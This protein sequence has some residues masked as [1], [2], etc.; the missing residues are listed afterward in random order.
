MTMTTIDCPRYFLICLMFFFV[1]ALFLCDK[2]TVGVGEAAVRNRLATE[3]RLPPGSSALT[4]LVSL[5]NATTRYGGDWRRAY[6][7]QRH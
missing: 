3:L 1:Q 7:A 2:A 4:R 6:V 5:Y